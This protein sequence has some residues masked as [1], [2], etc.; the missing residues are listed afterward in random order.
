METGTDIRWT[1]DPAHDLTDP[2]HRLSDRVDD[3]DCGHAAALVKLLKDRERDL[4]L[5]RRQLETRILQEMKRQGADKMATFPGPVYDDPTSDG[6]F[7]YVISRRVAKRRAKV[8]GAGLIRAV[9]ALA[10]DERMRVNKATGEVIPVDTQT[11]EM[12]ETAFRLEPRWSVLA[13]W[14]IEDNDYCGDTSYN[15]TMK[16]E[17]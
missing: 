10:S 8:D 16:V 7:T 12:V 2:I 17:T 5:I 11:L 15:E 6:G 1:D 4:A 3:Y 14:G 9:K 13:G